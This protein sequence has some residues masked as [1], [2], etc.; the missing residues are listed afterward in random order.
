MILLLMNLALAVDEPPPTWT[1]EESCALNSKDH[2]KRLEKYP[3]GVAIEVSNPTG[4]DIEL[5]AEGLD[6]HGEPIS[7]E[8]LGVVPAYSV[9]L[10]DTTFFTTEFS[11]LCTGDCDSL[12]ID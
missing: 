9:V 10:F 1:P 8:D 5:A 7:C 2:K 6:A 4:E 12:L 3:P 11:L